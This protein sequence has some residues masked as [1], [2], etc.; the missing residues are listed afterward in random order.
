MRIDKKLYLFG[1]SRWK[2]HFIRP[3]LKDYDKQNIYFINPIFRSH[4]DLAQKHGIDSSS[5][6][7]IW[8]R[9]DYQDIQDYALKNGNKIIRVEDGFIRSVGLGSDLTAPYSLVFDDEGIYFDPTVSSRLETII[10]SYDFKG[11]KSLI[12]E[13]KELRKKIISSKI[14]KYN[15]FDDKKLSVPNGKN[16][17]LVVGQVE[18][19]ASIKYGADGMTN[20]QLLKE[21]YQYN[22]DS[23]IIYKPHPD[24]LS[25]NRVG[26]I[27]ED[28]ALKYCDDIAIDISLHSVLNI[29]DEVHTMTSL[30]GFEALVLGKSVTTYGMP[31]Y[32]GWGLTIDNKICTRRARILDIDWLI[33]ATLILYPKYIN[34]HTK[35]YCKA[36][37]LIDI[38]LQEQQKIR[39]SVF[40]RIKI[41]LYSKISRTI[42]KLLSWVI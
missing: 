17:I 5:D 8:G 21:V 15:A 7:M 40:Y 18:D 10:N 42:Q 4:Y 23:Y 28:I 34:P 36:N 2:H 11:D 29:V 13:A 12:L 14:S 30:T 27:D 35:Q 16:I 26:N 32:A 1:F 38:L 37:E 19:D 20:L 9:K 6:I 39:S 25:G 3:F 31:F 33:A 22:K 24:V 41:N